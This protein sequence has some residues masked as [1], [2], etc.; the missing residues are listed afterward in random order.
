VECAIGILFNKQGFF[1]LRLMIVQIS[2][3]LQLK[4]VPN[5]TISF[6]K[7]TALNFRI[8]YIKVLLRVLK[9]L[10]LEVIFLERLCTVH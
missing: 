5:Y 2:S 10:A 3:I 4:F 6:A 7:K 8:H 9:L 1:I